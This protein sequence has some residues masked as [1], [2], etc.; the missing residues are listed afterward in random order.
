MVDLRIQSECFANAINLGILSR[1][2]LCGY[3]QLRKQTLL[4]SEAS[5]SSES[6]ISWSSSAMM[7]SVD[8]ERKTWGAR[9]DKRARS[10]YRAPCPSLIGG[11]VISYRP[12]TADQMSLKTEDQMKSAFLLVN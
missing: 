8:W 6:K 1:V 5:L 4:K 7:G 11:L 2:S 10:A 12:W 9:M 3:L